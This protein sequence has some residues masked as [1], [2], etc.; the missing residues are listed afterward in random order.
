MPSA[1]ALRAELLMP[2]RRQVSLFFCP[3]S[4]AAIVITRRLLI[5][6]AGPAR[7][8]ATAVIRNAMIE[9]FLHLLAQVAIEEETL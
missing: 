4:A 7:P 9:A 1:A 8:S 3:L 2:R 6:A 5:V